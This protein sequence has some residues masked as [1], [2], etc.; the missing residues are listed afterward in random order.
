MS[1]D[2]EY[3][4]PKGSSKSEVFV[5]SD[6]PTFVHTIVTKYPLSECQNWTVEQWEHNHKHFGDKYMEF[7]ANPT[8]KK[9]TIPVDSIDTE[10]CYVVIAHF[11]DG[12][13]DI[14]EVMQK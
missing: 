13:Y 14:S 4:S 5:I 11:A 8:A 7:T 6:A 12:S 3:I 2:Y 1:G 10:D 9:Y